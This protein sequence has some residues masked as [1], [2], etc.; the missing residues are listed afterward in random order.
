MKPVTGLQ[1]TLFTEVKGRIKEDDAAVP[2][3]EGDYEYRWAYA[4][5][6]EYRQWFRRPLASYDWT[7]LLDEVA[8]AGDKD[9]F[10][11]GGL[12]IS[13]NGRQMAWSS[14][15]NGSERFTLRGRY[16]TC[17]QT[18]AEAVLETRCNNL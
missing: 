14:D 13:N 11:L 18:L 12:S 3:R 6:A 5:G 2:W 10:R 1:D 8:E 17:G 7:L 15:D 9:F 4:T 16:L